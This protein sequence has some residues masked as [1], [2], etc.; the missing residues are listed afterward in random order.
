MKWQYAWQCACSGESTSLMTRIPSAKFWGP[1]LKGHRST[2]SCVFWEKRGY[3][4]EKRKGSGSAFSFKRM[5]PP[6]KKEVD[7][8]S[9]HV[10]LKFNVLTYCIVINRRKSN[11]IP[12]DEKHRFLNQP[13]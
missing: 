10:T 1:I 9:H 8:L 4:S 7:E 6:K 2:L 12:Q 13:V 11:K 5:Q 3:N